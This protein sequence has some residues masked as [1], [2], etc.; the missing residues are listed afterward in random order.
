MQGRFS[1]GA[2]AAQPGW[3]PLPQLRVPG[4]RQTW[5]LLPIPFNS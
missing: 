2:F 1:M 5:L 3:L 4:V